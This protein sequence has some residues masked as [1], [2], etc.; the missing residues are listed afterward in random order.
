[1]LVI[2]SIP[3]HVCMYARVSMTTIVYIPLCWQVLTYD[4]YFKQTVHE[5]PQEYYRVRCVKIY[6]YLEDDTMSVV[7]PAI[8]NRYC[9]YDTVLHST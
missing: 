4:A 6:Y 9:T 2:V 8:E 5:S 7:E 1:M 3:V